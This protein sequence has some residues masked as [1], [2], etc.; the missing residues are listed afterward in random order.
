[1]SSHLI[2]WRGF[3][4]NGDDE[5][6][7]AVV[8]EL[9]GGKACIWTWPCQLRGPGWLNEAHIAVITMQP[10]SR[11]KEAARCMYSSHSHP[12]IGTE[13]LKLWIGTAI[14]VL[15]VSS[16]RDKLWDEIH[17]VLSE[18]YDWSAHCLDFPN[19]SICHDLWLNLQQNHVMPAS[20]RERERER[21][22]RSL[23]GVFVNPCLLRSSLGTNLQSQTLLAIQDNIIM[24]SVGNAKDHMNWSPN[25]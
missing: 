4:S 9:Q 3:V 14:L 23:W 19:F 15:G 10:P 17:P 7:V 5:S 8:S 22:S 16:I 12:F 2:F 18:F 24:V 1:M 11:C 13:P 25:V 6:K 20:D 21:T